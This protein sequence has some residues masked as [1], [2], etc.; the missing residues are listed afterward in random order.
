MHDPARRLRPDRLRECRIENA[1]LKR[2]IRY[3]AVGRHAWLPRMQVGTSTECR[4]PIENA[5]KCA[6]VC[7]LLIDKRA[8]FVY[9]IDDI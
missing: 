1:V 8:D 5:K 3:V 4:K 9:N 2:A 7:N 6:L